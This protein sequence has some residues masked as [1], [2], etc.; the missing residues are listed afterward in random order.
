MEPNG[1]NESQEKTPK[2]YTP[3]EVATILKVS[4]TTVGRYLRNGKIRGSHIGGMWRVS[5]DEL[6][7]LKTLVIRKSPSP[8]DASLA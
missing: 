4:R 5:A 1:A 2:F 7:R 8:P 3:R 6:E